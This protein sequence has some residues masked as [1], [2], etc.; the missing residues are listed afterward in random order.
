V[1]NVLRLPRETVLSFF[2]PDPELDIT[3]LLERVRT[4]TLVMHGSEDLLNPLAVAEHVAARMPEA[5][6]RVFAGR[7]HMLMYSAPDEF[8]SVLR[9][10]AL[11]P[12]RRI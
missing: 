3:S 4:P 9:E 8:C 12:L 10:F 11:A 7:G 6:L 1:E 5:H 2:D